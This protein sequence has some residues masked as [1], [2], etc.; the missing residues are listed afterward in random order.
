[1]AIVQILDPAAQ[2]AIPNSTASALSPADELTNGQGGRRLRLV[3]AL[4]FA[5]GVGIKIGIQCLDPDNRCHCSN[6]SKP[7]SKAAAQRTNNIDR[8]GRRGL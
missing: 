1:M 3:A 4:L 6:C 7:I 8:Q 5:I 2:E